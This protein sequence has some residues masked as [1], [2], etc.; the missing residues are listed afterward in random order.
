M[1]IFSI[2]T[3]F[4]AI[5]GNSLT[6]SLVFAT[7][8]LGFSISGVVR[9]SLH[10]IGIWWILA[11]IVPIVLISLLAKNES[12]LK[13]RDKFKRTICYILLGGSLACAYLIYRFEDRMNEKYPDYISEQEL[14]ERRQ[15][16]A[17]SEGR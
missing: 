1:N 9:R 3:F 10:G 13:L 5:K 15:T 7:A 8:V 2:R 17:R 4:K 6:F 12:K 16:G 14:R 11:W